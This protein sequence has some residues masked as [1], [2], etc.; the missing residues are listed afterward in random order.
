VNIYVTLLCVCSGE[1]G[2][3]QPAAVVLAAGTRVWRRPG[4]RAHAV[5]RL[6]G[7]T[8]LPRPNCQLQPCALLSNVFV[9]T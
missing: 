3:G 7:R 6:E 5:C 2:G 4:R 1:R 9:L 8:H